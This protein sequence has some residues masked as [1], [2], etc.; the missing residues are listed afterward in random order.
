M[1]MNLT[2]KKIVEELDKYIVGQT[3]A[4]KAVAIALRARILRKK[5]SLEMQNE[6]YPKNILMVGPTGVGKTEIARRLAKIINAPFI[7]VEAT[8]YTEVGYIGKDVESIIRDL[9][10]IA[11]KNVKD[12]KKKEIE[13]EAKINAKKRILKELAQENSSLEAYEEFTK[14]LDKGLLNEKEIEIEVE[15]TPAPFSAFEV[16]LHG[17]MPSGSII[18]VSDLLGKTLG[19]QK[20][21]K[22]MKIKE[23]LETLEEEIKEEL[24]D[25]EEIMEEALKLTEEKGV[26][27]IDEIDKIA[28]SSNAKGGEVSREGVQRDLLPLIEG[29]T[30]LTKYGNVMTDHILFISSG[31]FYN[32]RPSDLS[33]EL[34]GRFPI[35]VELKALEKK[36]MIDILVK[37]KASLEKQYKALLK[38]EGVNLVFTEDGIEEIADL[39]IKLNS[40]VENIGARRLYT[41]LEKALEKTMFEVSELK[42]KDI[43]V[44]KNFIDLALKDIGK[45]LDLA[46]FIL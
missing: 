27:F 46:K 34:Q 25:N 9:V 43:T 19:P 31:A 42:E 16:P 7:K 30:V 5:L 23:A 35:R 13:K 21:R 12:S 44:D 11:V 15:A 8:K 38:A 24:T 40:E 17:N 6:I 22:K 10:E 28:F 1:D 41:L 39:A 45:K 36:D 18:Q 37:P 29:T 14:L 20:R 3:E 4:K 33:P 26:V 32:V 2:P